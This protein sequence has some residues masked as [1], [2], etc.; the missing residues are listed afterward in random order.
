MNDEWDKN[1]IQSL[2]CGPIWIWT[3]EWPRSA[4]LS[5]S[6]I[7]YA[8][9]MPVLRARVRVSGAFLP[10]HANINQWIASLSVPVFGS[11]HKLLIFKFIFTTI[12]HA[13]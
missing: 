13:A 4:R 12:I 2:H 9:L 11:I 10:V 3:L 8:R 5:L 6:I 1:H 7:S